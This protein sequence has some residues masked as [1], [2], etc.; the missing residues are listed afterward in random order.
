[1]K[2]V[3]SEIPEC[4]IGRR[5]RS[6]EDEVMSISDDERRHGRRHDRDD[7]L[8]ISDRACRERLLEEIREELLGERTDC[9]FDDEDDDDV[10]G[11]SEEPRRRERT[12]FQFNGCNGC[13]W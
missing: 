12:A 8:G 13:S 6:D 11:V 1:M 4:T 7:V 9:D 2:T 5:C 10:L 3:Y